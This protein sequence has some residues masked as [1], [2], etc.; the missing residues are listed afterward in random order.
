MALLV[1]MIVVATVAVLMVLI[2]MAVVAMMLLPV[3]FPLM[4]HHG[5]LFRQSLAVLHGVDELLAGELIPWGGNHGGPVVMGPEEGNGGI[6]FL[7]GDSVGT[8]EDNGGGAF[9]LVVVELAKVAHIHLALAGIC[10]GHGVAQLRAGHL[11]HCGHHVA[12]LAH[13][14]G[15]NDHPVGGI[16]GHHLLQGLAEIPHQGAADT[17]GVH[18]PDFDPRLL[19]EAAVNADFPEFVFNQHQLLPGVA[20][21]NHFFDEGCFPRAEKAGI[22][23]DFGQQNAP[24]IW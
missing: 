3:F 6:Q 15:L 4:H 23:I 12:E 24:S 20:L 16:L 2:V 18:L 8:A 9:N 14:G 7:L 17:A 19:E 11:L 13:A 5:Q 21:G 10:H 1:V 22:N